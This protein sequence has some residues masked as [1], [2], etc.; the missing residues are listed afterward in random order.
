MTASD[1][2]ARHLRRLFAC[3]DCS[4]VEGRPVTGAV[5]GAKIMLVGQAPGPREEDA[6]RPFAWTAGRRL[7]EWVERLG[8]SEEEFRARVHIC[9]VARCF[10]GRDPKGGGDR[11]PSNEEITN[12]AKHLD[13]EIELLSPLLV[14]IVGTLAAARFIGN[15]SLVDVVGRLHQTAREGRKFDAAV[16]PHPSGRSTWLNSENNRALLGRSLD[17]I[18]GH[19]A[20]RATFG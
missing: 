18:A 20:F 3:R 5:P 7:F 9:A 10:P 4:S 15:S 12:C 19:E 1:A 8:V 13:R 11:L 6:G 14:I 2:F 17:L 16:L